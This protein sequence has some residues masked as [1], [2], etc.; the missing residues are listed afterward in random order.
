[1]CLPAKN[2]KNKTRNF[3]TNSTDFKKW[4]TLKN[5]VKPDQWTFQ[6]CYVKI[7]WSV[8]SFEWIFYSFMF[9]HHGLAIGK[10]L[11]QLSFADLLMLTHLL[12][13]YPQI[14]FFNITTSHIRSLETLGAKKLVVENMTF[15]N[16]NFCFK[17]QMLSSTTK[18]SFVFLEMASSLLSFL[19]KCL[20][21]TKS[22]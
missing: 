11:V 17:I 2:P 14:T 4:S 1:M 18:P 22:E 3:V 10:I 20:P 6:L 19:W 21:N 7:H 15:Q 8:L 13:P 12:T 16:S 5:K 9:L